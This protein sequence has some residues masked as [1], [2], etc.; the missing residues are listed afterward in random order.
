MRILHVSHAGLPDVRVEKTALTMKHRG[1]EVVFLGGGPI[2]GQHFNVF[3]EFHS[4]E[5]GNSLRIVFDPT[6]KQRWLNRIRELRPD[7]VHAHNCVVGHFLASSKFPT[8]FNDHEYLSKQIAKFEVRPFIRRMAV[9]PMAKMFPKWERMLLERF[10]TL[11]THPNMTEAHQRF[12]KSVATIP[13]VPMRMQIEGF[14]EP[15]ERQG[16][17][18]VGGDFKLAMFMPHRNLEGLRDIIDFDILTGIPYREMMQ[19]L[20]KYRVGLTAWHS[21]QWHRYSDANKNY[22][23]MHAGLPVV[24]NHIIKDAL[25]ST[26]PYVLGFRNYDE[27]PQIIKSVS[28]FDHQAIREYALKH[29]IW[30]KF[31]DI[32]LAAYD[33][34]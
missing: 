12:G 3:D 30:E 9:K 8:I 11:T 28:N 6:V 34:L 27:I 25:F 23:Y 15:A 17:A 7:V 19:K 13:N 1:H 10:P 31:E 20:M 22:E 21:H 5:L 18:Y 4:L 16:N 26:N 14:A 29:Y 2:T 33:A 32:I 24:T